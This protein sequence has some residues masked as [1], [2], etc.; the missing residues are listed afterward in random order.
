MKYSVEVEESKNDTWLKQEYV[1][2]SLI[3]GTMKHTSIITTLCL[4][5]FNVQ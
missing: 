3:L 4:M 1:R 5:L 2:W